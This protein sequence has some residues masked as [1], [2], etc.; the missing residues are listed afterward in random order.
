MVLG[1]LPGVESKENGASARATGAIAARKKTSQ[2]RRHERKNIRRQS[3]KHPET[4]TGDE[5]HKI[6]WAAI[7]IKPAWSL[8]KFGVPPNASD[9]ILNRYVSDS[10]FA[11]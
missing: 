8:L 9:A 1:S 5:A 2:F 4:S 6:F 7:G 10:R 3:A 11:R